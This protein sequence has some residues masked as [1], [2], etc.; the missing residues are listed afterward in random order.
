[1]LRRSRSV[2]AAAVVAAVALV[3]CSSSDG[4]VPAGGDDT[5]SVVAS[6]GAWGDIAARVGGNAVTVTSII[7]DPE[8]DP[9]EYEASAQDQ[10]VL[11]KADVVIENGGGFDDFIQRMIAASNNDD[12]VLIS[13]VDTSG[14]E[15]AGG[16]ELNEHFWYDYPSVKNMIEAL[17]SSFAKLDPGSAA[18]FERNA[19]QL[20]AEVDGLI[21][22]TADLRKEYAGTPIGITEP[23][24]FYLLEA[25]GLD[26]TT[27]EDFSEALE[28]GDDV[29]PALMLDIL[30]LYEKHEVDVLVYKEQRTGPQNEQ[31]LAAARDNDI[32]VVMV[33]ETFPPGQNYITWMNGILDELASAL[34]R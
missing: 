16:G 18:T 33:Q 32:P 15:A 20:T 27:P 29:A 28:E 23:L 13:A 34:A 12:A 8:K 11:S 2:V 26:N 25:I 10:L 30:D 31:V 7:E 17:V 14:R 24:A 19:E 3:G 9:H 5:I 6:L 1:M 4:A 22:R 21:E